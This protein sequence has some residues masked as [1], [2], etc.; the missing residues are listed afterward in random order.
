[1]HADRVPHARGGTGPDRCDAQYNAAMDGTY[2][3]CVQARFSATHALRLPEGTI[4][5]LHG[6]DWRVAVT[7]CGRRLDACGLL[8]D[9]HAL[10]ARLASLCRELHHRH[11]NDL[12]DFAQQPPSAEQIARWFAT[13]I[14][15]DLPAGVRVA[16]VEVE[17]TPGCVARFRPAVNPDAPNQ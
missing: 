8:I 6:H 5:P 11:L 2:E 4:E 17:E 12:P 9:F 15:A 7:L 1:M 16:C 10:E 3:V 14:D 13:R